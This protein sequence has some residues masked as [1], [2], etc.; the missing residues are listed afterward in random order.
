MKYVV[1]LGRILFAAI[2]VFAIMGHFSRMAIA[3]AGAHGVPLA[4]ILVPLSGIIAFVGGLSIAVGYKARWGAW[5]IVIFLVPVTLTMHKFWGSGDALEIGL[6]QV[7]FMKNL[8]MLGGALM[9][10][11][12]G[13]GPLSLDFQKKKR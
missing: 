10:A 7:M 12:F 3:Y 9:I 8:S 11:Y 6:Q 4:Q 2:F 5:L 13:S 1:L